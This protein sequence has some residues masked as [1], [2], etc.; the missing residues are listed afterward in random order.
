MIGLP[1]SLAPLDCGRDLLIDAALGEAASAS[2]SWQ[3][4]REA[5]GDPLIDPVA[6]RW[7]PLID[8]NLAAADMPP[9]DRIVLEQARR[10]IWLTNVQRL[11]HAREASGLL[12]GAGIRPVLLKGAALAQTI[13]SR[14]VLRPIG[15]VDLLV[16]PTDATAALALLRAHG[17]TPLRHVRDE[18]RRWRHAIDL[19]QPS[20]AALDL[21]WHL[22]PEN[23]SAGIDEGVWRRVRPLGAPGHPAFVLAPIDQLLHICAHGLRWSPVHS[24]HWIA[25]AVY[26]LRH[27][28]HAID[29]DVLPREAAR[30]QLTRQLAA[31]LRLVAT[32]EPSRVPSEIVRAMEGTR[33]TWRERVETRVKGKPVV[34]AAGVIGLWCRWRRL[35]EALGS[36]AP[37]WRR[38]LATAVGVDPERSLLPWAWRHVRNRAAEMFSGRK[39]RGTTLV[40]RLAPGSGRT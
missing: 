9:A 34:S 13:Y 26:L 10:S 32:I 35:V 30:R 16:H 5:V 24:G 15:D 27:E 19:T 7:L 39:R 20:G 22:L 29:W 17:W 2:R 11:E 18:D 6:L 38:F 12:A 36:D 40:P 33:V 4:Y 14:H 28:S 23:V 3:R 1:A 31:A 37:S 8:A 21:H 25:D